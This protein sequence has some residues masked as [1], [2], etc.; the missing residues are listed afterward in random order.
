VEDDGCGFDYAA[1]RKNMNRCLGII[2]MEERITLMG[3]SLTVESS[4]G[5]GTFVRAE[6][7]LEKPDQSSEADGSPDASAEIS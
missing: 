1:V 7:P 2:G 4:P 3:G 6:I 5:K